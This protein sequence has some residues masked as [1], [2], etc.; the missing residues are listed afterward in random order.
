[1]W[2][3]MLHKK[4]DFKMWFLSPTNANYYICRTIENWVSKKIM[5]VD[6]KLEHDQN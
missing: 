3:T 1:M 6:T 2:H 5:H 4:I